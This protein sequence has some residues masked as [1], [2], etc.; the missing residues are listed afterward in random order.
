M[1]SINDE[2]T[3]NQYQGLANDVVA[4]KEYVITTVTTFIQEHVINHIPEVN[5]VKND[6]KCRE[7]GKTYVQP[8]SLQNHEMKVHGITTYT[9]ITTS[10]TEKIDHLHNYTTQL[11]V[12]LLLRL[13]H[14]DA[15]KLGDGA[16]VVRL[17]K[18]FCLYCKVS[19]C[20]KYAIALLELQCQV[21]CLLSPRLAHSLTWNRFVNHK[22]QIDTNH[23][24][25][26][27]IEHDNK[28]FK[29]DCHSYRGEITDR[30]I[31]RVSR[32]IETSE[33]IVQ[34]FDSMTNVKRP[35][36]S[37]TRLSTEEDVGRL[38]GHLLPIKPFSK[39]PGRAHAS[40]PC[41]EHSILDKL[42]MDKLRVWLIHSTKKFG[43]SHIYKI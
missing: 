36:G 7:C 26:L 10:T 14:N 43:N 30:T 24:M 35:S 11:L 21:N 18:Y 4:K 12:F 20:P 40:F 34:K 2:P 9:P 27:D 16:R 29:D 22:G 23:P 38:V 25:D 6:L 17:Y 8:K 42:D 37:H 28:Y 13:N 3:Q 31:T 39:V 15:I 5:V 19:N 1:K 41:M 32:S 33:C